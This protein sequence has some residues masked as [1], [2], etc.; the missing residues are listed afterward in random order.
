MA[1]KLRLKSM[2]AVHRLVIKTSGGRLGWQGGGMPVL[3]LTTTGRK[4]GDSRPT[5]LSSPLQ[6][7]DT[8]VVVALGG[9]GPSHPAWYLNAC[10]EPRVT[11]KWQGAAPQPMMARTAD[12]AERD[13][14]W[15]LITERFP[16]F[17]K[18]QAETDRQLPLVLLEPTAEPC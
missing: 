4:S 13:R 2:N 3:E 16:D 9:G 12:Q 11:M 10:A 14:M 7:G 1:S 17:A 8:V 18:W 5:M 15:P 6:D